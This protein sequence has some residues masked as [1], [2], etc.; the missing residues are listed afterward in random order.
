MKNLHLQHP[1]DCVLWGDLSILNWFVTPGHLSVKIDGCPAIVW[2]TNPANGQ[3]F[4]GTKSVFNKVKIKINHNHE[5][6][7]LH[8]EGEVAEIL[9]RAFD[10]LPRTD[11]IFQGDVIGLGNSDQ[12]T[13]NTITY[14]FSEK[15]DALIVAPH[16]EYVAENDLRNAVASTLTRKLQSNEYTLFVQPNAY[17][18]GEQ[19]A[20]YDVN[21]I[22]DFARQMAMLVQF[23]KTQ[24]EIRIIQKALNDCIRNQTEVNEN[25]IAEL[26]N[27]DVNLIRL[28]KL[29]KSIKDDCLYLCR[30]NGPAAFIGLDRID[31]E[32]Y[33]LSNEYGTHKLVNREFF[34]YAN[35]T[36]GK[37]N[38]MCA[39]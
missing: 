28:W 37:M 20:F 7:D 32:G 13:P 2:G 36:M 27:C 33:V 39:G 26:T 3:F 14:L 6:I 11:S 24:K 19:N 16:T 21:E 34:S 30:N 35:F 12:Y 25:E 15:I 8:H 5:E 23:P 1:E 29:V 10:S 4:V 22:C 31:A 9:H 38:R 18:F 17:I